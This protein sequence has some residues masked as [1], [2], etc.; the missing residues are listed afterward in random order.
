MKKHL[1]AAGALALTV[2][3]ASAGIGS[4]QG[5]AVPEI[6]FA[7]TPKAVKVAPGTQIG[8]GFNPR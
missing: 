6:E 7:V 4:A 2:A 1:L 3:G 8:A 5:P